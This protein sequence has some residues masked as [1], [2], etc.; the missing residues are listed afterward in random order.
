M[1]PAVPADVRRLVADRAARACEYC[2]IPESLTYFGCQID[3]IVSVKHG[4][5]TTPDNLCYACVFCNRFK[6]AD[7][8]SVDSDSGVFVRFFNPRR[9]RWNEHFE[10]VGARIEPRS[11]IG[12]A[13][14]RILRFN[15]TDRILERRAFQG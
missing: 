7:I 13:T 10:Q 4:G 8:G 5:K 1:S 11:A 12:E 15:D 6:G 3:H 14:A 9:D 2:G